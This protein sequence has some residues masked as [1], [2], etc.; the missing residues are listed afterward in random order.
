MLITRDRDFYRTMMIVALPAALQSLLSLLVVMV[1]NIMVGSLSDLAFS[2]VSMSNSVTA[3]FTALMFGLASGSSALISQYWGKKDMGSI[4][5]IFAVV[6]KICSSSAIIISALV[7]FFPG[8]TLKIVT[9][10]SVIIAEAIIYLRIVSLSYLLFGISS[11]MVMMLR[12]VE[13]VKITLYI[14]IGS[15]IANISLNYILIFGHLGFPAM[16]IKGAAIATLLTRIIELI[17]VYI[18]TF[19]VQKRID[20]KISDLFRKTSMIKDYVL[21][22][23]PI[24]LGDTQWALIGLF[25]A[26][27]VGHLGAL[28]ITANSVAGNIM[29]L[30]M[31]F[32]GAMA[33]GACVVI[34]KSVG[35]GNYDKTRE[36]SRTIQILFAGLGIFSSMVIFLTRHL[37]TA[38]FTG[39]SAEAISLASTFI[40]IGALTMIGTTYHASCFIGINRG[41]GDGRFVVMIDM[42][43][44]WLIVLPLSYLAAFVFK[45]PLPVVFLMLYIDQCFKWLIAFLRLRGNKWIRNVTR[46]AV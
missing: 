35:T 32:T 33:G 11:S 6:F 36:Y 1:D 3:L 13:T 31:L 39:L 26:S 25:K 23:L 14:S 42:I 46:E 20:L 18:Y 41:S 19:K 24:A 10:D 43:C 29:P 21:H 15:L 38:L 45:W 9:N 34:G 5:E 22:G 17:I 37:T 4:K 7:F 16:G 44:G 8:R 27:I 12:F 2:A 30:G 28:M 40:A